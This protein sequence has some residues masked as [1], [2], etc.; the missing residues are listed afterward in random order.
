MYLVNKCVSVYDPRFLQFFYP[1]YPIVNKIDDTIDFSNGVIYTGMVTEK[2]LTRLHVL[3][4]NKVIIVS[5]YGEVNL[6]TPEEIAKSYY[7]DLTERALKKYKDYDIDEFIEHFKRDYLLGRK[8]TAPKP[9]ASEMYNLFK[10]TILSTDTLLKTYFSVISKVN[11]NI[12]ASSI[13]TFLLR[14]L[15]KDVENRRTYS[16]KELIITANK[17]Y[18]DRIKVEIDKYLKSK[19]SREVALLFLLLSLNE[20]RS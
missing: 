19:Q 8:V 4:N 9:I 14:V 18:G 3:T 13:F 7:P 12:V 11:I 20:V 17:M 1:N 6:N 2:I 10:A 15:T 16:Y 5:P